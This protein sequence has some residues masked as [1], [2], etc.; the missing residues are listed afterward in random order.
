MQSIDS[1]RNRVANSRIAVV[2]HLFYVD[3]FDEVLDDLKN[4]VE[5]FD[6]FITT[7]FEA[8]IPKILEAANLRGQWVAVQLC[9]NKGRDV[10][11]FVAFY[12]TGRLDHYDAVLKLH[13]KKS[14]Y[15]NQGDYW[16]RALYKA[17]CGDSMTVLRTLR[18]IREK[19]C[20]VVGPAK[21]FL[22]SQ[23]FWGANRECLSKILQNCNVKYEGEYPELAFFAGTMFWFAPKAIAAMHDAK[24]EVLEFDAE[25][26]KQDGTLAHGWERAF[27]LL[28]RDAGYRVSSA[29]LDGKD[30][31]KF[32]SSRNKVP[33]LAVNNLQN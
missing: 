15:S 26:G 19:G 33:V 25:N 4:I 30:I 32:D 6:L 29:T 18:L 7:P 11:P 5:P 2:V 20:G 12:R 17:L 9:R 27:C 13:T 8:D 22:T 1:V 28:A 10:G 23:E 24:G 21:Y 14:H 16:R 3:L 31:F